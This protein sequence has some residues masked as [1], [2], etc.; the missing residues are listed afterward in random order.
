MYP[1]HTDGSDDDFA[2]LCE[3][4]DFP[5]SFIGMLL[6]VASTS[7]RNWRKGT[8]QVPPGIMIEMA[9]L[10]RLVEGWFMWKQKRQN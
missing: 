4:L 8:H 7:V 1:I 3:R 5:D 9:E 2:A 6:E 10:V